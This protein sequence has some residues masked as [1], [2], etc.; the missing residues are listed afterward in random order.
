MSIVQDRSY[1][2]HVKEVRLGKSRRIHTRSTTQIL[3]S[4][5]CKF[6]RPLPRLPSQPQG[7]CLA[8][9]FPPPV[10]PLSIKAYSRSKPVL[11]DWNVPSEAPS[12][13]CSA[14]GRNMLKLILR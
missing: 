9:R 12:R 8:D 10:R 1:S 6:H 5:M 3:A 13:T 4:S 7:R 14:G 2:I 11:D